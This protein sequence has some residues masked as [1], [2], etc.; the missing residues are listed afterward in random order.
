MQNKKSKNEMDALRLRMKTDTNNWSVRI[1]F[2]YII[3]AIYYTIIIQN[4]D[5]YESKD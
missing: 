4:I 3:V 2:N 5:I 1:S